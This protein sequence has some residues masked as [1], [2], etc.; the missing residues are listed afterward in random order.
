MLDDALE[1]FGVRPHTECPPS[2]IDMTWYSSDC[3]NWYI[4]LTLCSS[5]CGR[6]WDCC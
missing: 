5:D 2:V 4:F 3:S 1:M 6:W